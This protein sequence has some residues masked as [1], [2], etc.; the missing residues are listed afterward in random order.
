MAIDPRSRDAAGGR[1]SGPPASPRS[2]EKSFKIVLGVAAVLALL[3]PA[4]SAQ[5]KG[6][7]ARLI[8]VEKKY[9]EASAMLEAGLPGYPAADKSDAAALLAYCR[10][11]LTDEAG[12]IRWIVEFM[13]AYGGADSG[14]A[15]MGLLPQADVLG[16]LTRWRIRYPRI[17]G[18]SL[19]K[20]VGDDV[21]MPEGIL[22]LAVEM[23]APAYYKFSGDG[24][25]VKAGQLLA[26][27][28]VIALDA[29]RLFLASGRHAYRLEVMSGSLVLTRTIDLAVEVASSRPQPEATAPGQS[30]RPLE[31]SLTIYIGGEPVLESRKTIR[32]VP[33]DLGIKPNQ[34]PFGFRPDAVVRKDDPSRIGGVSVLNAIGYVYGL[35]KDLFNKRGKKGVPP[36]KVETVQDLSLT[37]VSKDADGIDYETKI[38]LKLSSRALPYALR[39]PNPGFATAR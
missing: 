32:T 2:R 30:A 9:A 25:T 22:P 16:Y 18:I 33:M 36:P 4:L 3:A 23:A 20:G 10:S 26:G 11:R 14:F 29:N 28:N 6:E 7:A 15:Y 17:V 13:D 1:P 12:E 37:F 31:Y 27:F 19:V 38:G 34:N 21:I 8:G 5:W 35:L 39:T 24:E